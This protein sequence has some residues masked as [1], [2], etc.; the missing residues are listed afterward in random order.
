MISLIERGEASPT[1]VLLERLAWG[2]GVPLAR[3]FDAPADE[4]AAPQAIVRHAGQPQWRD[5][6][7]GYLRRNVSPLHRPSPI[8]IVDVDFPAGP[9]CPTR[10]ARAISPCINR[11]RSCPD[12]SR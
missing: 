2:L 8:Q 1:A 12:G 5:S 11:C 6:A 10:P 3:M 4:S 7:S 9:A